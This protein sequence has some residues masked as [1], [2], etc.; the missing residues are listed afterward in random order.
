MESKCYGITQ[1]NN[2]FCNTDNVFES[3]KLDVSKIGKT[4]NF[5]FFDK[6]L[7]LD[8]QNFQKI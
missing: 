5:C 8:L 2:S 6:I 7:E 4:I 3:T 1:C